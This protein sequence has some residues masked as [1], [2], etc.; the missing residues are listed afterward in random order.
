MRD[1]ELE[2]LPEWRFCNIPLGA[3]APLR[4]DW[5]LNPLTLDQVSGPGVGVIMGRASGGLFVVDFDG[6]WAWDWWQQQG[7]SDIDL[8]TVSWTSGRRDRAQFGFRLPERYWD[9]FDNL[10]RMII[11]IKDPQAQGSSVDGIEFRWGSDRSGRQSVL[12]PTQHPDPRYADDLTR[13]YDKKD[14]QRH[15]GVMVNYAWLRPPSAGAWRPLP[16]EIIDWFISYVPER[17]QW[18]EPKNVVCDEKIKIDDRHLDDV[19]SLLER[20]RRHEG[21]KI[22]SDRNLWRDRSWSVFHYLGRDVG[23]VVMSE[24]FPELEPGEYQKL[25]ESYDPSRSPQIKSIY[26]AIKDYE[27]HSLKRR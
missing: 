1:T 11:Q 18:A 16:Q 12:P 17:R 23:A 6:T 4:P 19:R 5:Q 25:K 10:Q 7:W 26:R 9:Q 13:A 21:P 22:T 3:K 24:F 15:Q 27:H 20:L 14:P 2:L 8:S